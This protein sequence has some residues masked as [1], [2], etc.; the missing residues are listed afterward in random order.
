M[1]KG[2]L[3][4]WDSLSVKQ[5]SWMLLFGESLA[6]SGA[7]SSAIAA[8]LSP[9]THFREKGFITTISWVQLLV[10]AI[11][12]WLIY[13]FAKN[14]TNLHLKKSSFL[15]QVIV[16]GLVFLALDESLSIHEQIDTLTHDW[17]QIEETSITDLAD[18]L[19]IALYLLFFL[20]YIWWQR[21]IIGLFKPSFHWFWLACGLTVGTIVFD[22]VSNN[23]LFLALVFDRPAVLSITQ[24]WLNTIE[25][26]LKIFA[27]GMFI[28]GIYHCWLIAK[29]ANTEN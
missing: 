4:S 7:I 21:Q 6:V 29:S 27:E 16:W 22:I 26:A 28:I 9:F 15:W 5:F 23:D 17:L 3:S 20:V 1:K 11:L 24:K 14:S 25:E 18:D 10:A 8:G 12:A 2:W 19:M 13:R